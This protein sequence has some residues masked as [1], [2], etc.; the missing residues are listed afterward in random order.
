MLHPILETNA[1]YTF[2][3][4]FKLNAE[5]DL[6]LAELGYGFQIEMLTLPRAKLETDQFASLAEQLTETPYFVNL[7][8]ETARREFLIAPILREVARYTQARIRVEFSI[9]VN[10]QLKGTLDYLL[11]K[12][13][14][15]LIV[16]AKNADLSQGFTQLAVELIAVNQWHQTSH[17]HLYGAV[18]TGDI[19]RFGMLE[20]ITKQVTQDVNLYRAPADLQDLMAILVGI[21]NG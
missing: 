16:E 7:A 13:T 6:I 17:T 18:T 10:E 21:L 4:Y 3:D 20:R 8:N 1:T 2:A 9:R 15:L 11:Q 19:W 5:I 14:N 12:Q